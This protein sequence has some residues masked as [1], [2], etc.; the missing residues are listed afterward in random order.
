MSTQFLS[1]DGLR[2]VIA[3]LREEIHE[4]E[5]RM[6]RVP[7]NCVNCCAP[8]DGWECQYCGTQYAAVE[9]K[10]CRR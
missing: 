9:Y 4:S 10:P 1:T 2:L 6:A 8:F 7:K 3:K 5:M